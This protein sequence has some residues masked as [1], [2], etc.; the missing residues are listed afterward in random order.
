MQKGVFINFFSISKFFLILKVNHESK[1]N[2]LMRSKFSKPNQ[3]WRFE[4][5]EYCLFYFILFEYYLN[6]DGFSRLVSILTRGGGVRIFDGCSVNVSF[7]LK[8]VLVIL[9]VLFVYSHSQQFTYI[10]LPSI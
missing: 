10:Q 1:P 2:K 7:L 6:L 4:F 3:S 8:S 5:G 9:L